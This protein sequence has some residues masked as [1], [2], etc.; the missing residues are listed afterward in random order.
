MLLEKAYGRS[1]KTT[2]HE[3]LAELSKTWAE[4]SGLLGVK[5]D[6]FVISATPYEKLKAHYGDGEWSRE[7]FASRNILFP[8]P[9]GDGAYLLPVFG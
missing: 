3:R 6:A 4:K 9:I 2:L 1:D 5:L 7:N 8:D